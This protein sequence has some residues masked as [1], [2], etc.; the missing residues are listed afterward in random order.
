MTRVG[1]DRLCETYAFIKEDTIPCVVSVAL[2]LFI[3]GGFSMSMYYEIHRFNLLEFWVVC[4]VVYVH[5][6]TSQIRTS[7]VD[8]RTDPNYYVV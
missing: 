7:G 3:R 4:Y 5:I 8:T 6:D 2:T 1:F